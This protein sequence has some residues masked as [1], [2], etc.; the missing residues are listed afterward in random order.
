MHEGAPPKE[1]ATSVLAE[2]DHAIIADVDPMMDIERAP[3]LE[4]VAGVER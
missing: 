2:V 1:D 4:V 3:Y